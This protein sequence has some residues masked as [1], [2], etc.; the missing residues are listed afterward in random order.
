ML[1]TSKIFSDCFAVTPYMA[2][3][4]LKVSL[5]EMNEQSIIQMDLILL[6]DSFNQHIILTALAEPCHWLHVSTS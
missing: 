1:I 3:L 4:C 2:S 6:I 5:K